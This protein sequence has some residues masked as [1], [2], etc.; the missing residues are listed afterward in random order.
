VVLPL[1]TR[2]ILDAVTGSS[3][4]ALHTV[5][6]W[7]VIAA[8]CLAQNIP[9]HTLYIRSISRAMREAQR[10]LR[11]A[12]VIRLQQLSIAFTAT[13]MRADYRPSCFAM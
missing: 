4:H 9:V 6:V 10:D 5:I 1:A 12:L 13:P 11:S 3:S 8:I 7:A 2:N